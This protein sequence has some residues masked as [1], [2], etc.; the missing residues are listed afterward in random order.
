MWYLV[1]ILKKYCSILPLSGGIVPDFLHLTCSTYKTSAHTVPLKCNVRDSHSRLDH[2]QSTIEG[3]TYKRPRNKFVF[4]SLNS[5][6]TINSYSGVWT[7]SRADFRVTRNCSARYWLV[8]VAR[9][10]RVTSVLASSPASA[11]TFHHV[12]NQ[13]A[14]YA[15]RCFLICFIYLFIYLKLYSIQAEG[16]QSLVAL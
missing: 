2:S 6:V 14:V 4:G 10:L 12:K 15:Q 5:R 1:Y 3:V 9:E 11:I 16:L 8:R 7:L 13:K